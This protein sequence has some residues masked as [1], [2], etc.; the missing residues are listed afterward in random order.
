[1]NTTQW[2]QKVWGL[3]RCIYSGLCYSIHELELNK[4]GFC[5]FHYHKERANWF[6]VETGIVRVV[7]AFGWKI[8]HSDLHPG[9]QLRIDAGIPHQ[10]QVLENGLMIEEYST[11]YSVRISDKDIYRLSE[12]GKGFDFGS[13]CDKVG[14]I[15]AD[16]ELW[17]GE[18]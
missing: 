3:T 4:G 10:F 7:W 9:N 8:N 5:S 1:M 16:G 2:E 12:G 18:W 15:R 14:I 11:P 17:T 13:A 6:R